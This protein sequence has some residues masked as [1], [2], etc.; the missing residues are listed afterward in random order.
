MPASPSSR[1]FKLSPQIAA[2]LKQHIE[3]SKLERDDLLFLYRPEESAPQPKLGS[4]QNPE[5]TE[6]NAAGRRY[7]HG[8]LSA[9][10]PGKCRCAY[11]KNVYAVYR[12]ERR[13][14]G[15][16]RRPRR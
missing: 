14:S 5:L 12:A 4:A 11:C 7:R 6:P 3:D 13:A 9:Y 8:M 2:K 15:D 10:S 1:R 16:P